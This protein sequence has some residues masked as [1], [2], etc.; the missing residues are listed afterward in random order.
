MIVGS[1]DSDLKGISAT[2]CRRRNCH[3]TGNG[4]FAGP[5]REQSAERRRKAGNRRIAVT[6]YSPPR[7]R[8]ALAWHKAYSH[9]RVCVRGDL[10][11]C[12]AVGR[13]SSLL[14]ALTLFT[15][16]ATITRLRSQTSGPSTRMV[17]VDGRPMRVRSQG[18]EQRQPGQAVVVLEAG[19]GSGLEA[20]DPVFTAIAELAPVIVYDRRGLGQSEADGQPQTIRH[21]AASLHALLTALQVRHLRMVGQSMAE[22]SSERMRRHTR[23]R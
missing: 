19:A 6:A 23:P 1:E 18:L 12:S 3:T 17:T 2:A 5:A 16:I 9:S 20:W 8:V 14:L 13:H 10:C 22:Y 7:R 11:D 15:A 4:V 21:V